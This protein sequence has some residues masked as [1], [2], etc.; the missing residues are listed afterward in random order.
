MKYRVGPEWGV[1][2]RKFDWHIK[3]FSEITTYVGRDF[4][5]ENWW[6]IRNTWSDEDDISMENILVM[7]K[8]LLIENT[9]VE[10]TLVEKTLVENTP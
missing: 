1:Y 10:N 5:Q 4:T 9:V 7:E 3:Y 8:T 6:S 2:D